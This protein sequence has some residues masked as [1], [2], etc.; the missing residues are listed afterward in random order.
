M[1]RERLSL[2][3]VANKAPHPPPFPAA[4]G[5][6]DTV[7]RGFRRAEPAEN[8]LRSAPPAPGRGRE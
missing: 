3:F 6:G 4:A 7:M 5:K 8:P 1:E 2:L